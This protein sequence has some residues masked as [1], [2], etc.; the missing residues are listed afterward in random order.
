MAS[1]R[2]PSRSRRLVAVV[3]LV[4]LGVFTLP[5]VA[6]VIDTIDENLV[7]PVHVALVL[8][9]GIGTWTFVPGVAAPD[10]PTSR[11]IAVGAAIGF[12]AAI[13]A[14]VVFFLLLSGFS[15]A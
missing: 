7:A 5:L 14:Y 10:M 4:L 13:T 9:A 6:L 12:L 15:G 11:R 3:L 2:P 1:G 8:A